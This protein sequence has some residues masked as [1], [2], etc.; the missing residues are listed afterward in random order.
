MADSCAHSEEAETA[1]ELNSTMEASGLAAMRA[2]GASTAD[3]LGVRGNQIKRSIRSFD[4]ACV[5]FI[6]INQITHFYNFANENPR[7]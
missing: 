2:R 7:F 3:E 1:S 6:H 5:P 4:D